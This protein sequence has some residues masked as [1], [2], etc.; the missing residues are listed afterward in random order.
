MMT[1]FELLPSLDMDAIYRRKKGSGMTPRDASIKFIPC[2]HKKP[3][4]PG[5]WSCYA[6][7]QTRDWQG[8]VMRITAEQIS[9]GVPFGTSCV[10]GPMPEPLK[11]MID[12]APQ[13][14]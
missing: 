6:E 4:M 3:T 7:D 13:E 11:E 14:V 10:F 12:A 5:L 1:T 8:T 9:R 2:W